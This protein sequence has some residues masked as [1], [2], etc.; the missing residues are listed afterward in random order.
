MKLIRTHFNF[1]SI[2]EV[3]KMNVSIDRYGYDIS[4]GFPELVA[5]RL[6]NHSVDLAF[7]IYS[8]IIYDNVDTE[9]SS[10]AV[11]ECYGWAVPARM[12][13]STPTH[14]PIL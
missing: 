8:H 11:S 14:S 12:G 4:S 2:I 3:P 10:V 9:F 13:K 5:A 1:T 6:T 7:G